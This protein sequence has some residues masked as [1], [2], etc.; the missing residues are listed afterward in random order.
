MATILLVA[1]DGPVAGHMVRTLRQA[2]HTPIFASDARSALQEALGCPDIVLFDLGLPDLP[3]EK[4]LRHLTSQ[5][6]TADIPVLVITESTE[7]AARLR[8]SQKGSL[9]DI[10]L[11][12]VSGAQLRE[13]V[14]N[15]LAGQG[16]LDTDALRLARQRQRELI[17]RLI[18]EGPDPLVFHVYRRL[19]A[20]RTRPKSPTSE[21]VLSW[22]EIAE[23]AKREGVL[24][25]EQARLLRRVPLAAPQTGGEDSV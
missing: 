5:P 11:T 6:E 22:A 17:R 25:A 16:E 4:L 1:N 20:D 9:A 2:G 21:D 8:G 15:A 18:L 13:A 7:A 23:W 12:P 19:C 10:L 24:D 14:G 3:M